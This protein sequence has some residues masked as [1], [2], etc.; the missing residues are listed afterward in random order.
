[1]LQSQ[2]VHRHDACSGSSPSPQWHFDGHRWL[3]SFLVLL[4][5]WE[6]RADWRK[7]VREFVQEECQPPRLRRELRKLLR[8]LER[9]SKQRDVWTA[10]LQEITQTITDQIETMT[11]A[12]LARTDCGSATI[13]SPCPETHSDC[14]VIAE[15]QPP[16]RTAEPEA[17]LSIAHS[18]PLPATMSRSVPIESSAMSLD[19]T[20]TVAPATTQGVEQFYGL[21]EQAP[22]ACLLVD[23]QGKVNYINAAGQLLFHEHSVTLGFGPDELVGN[24]YARLQQALPGLKKVTAH[25]SQVITL[26]DAKLEVSQRVVLNDLGRPVGTA[27]YLNNVTTLSQLQTDMTDASGKLDA[28]SRTN[29]VIEFQLDGTILT[30]NENFLSA[31]GYSLSEI[32]G[33]HHGIFADDAYRTSPEYREFWARLNRGENISGEMRRVAKGGREIWIRAIYS[34]MRDASGKL[35]KVVKF[36]TDIT[37]EVRSRASMADAAGKMEA[38]N[39]TNAVIEFKLD[40]TIVTANDNFL[41]AVGYS[42][43]EI[44]G[45]HH[46]MFVDSAYRMSPDY[47]EFWAKLNRGESVSGEMKRIA[48]GGREIWIRAIYAP[49]KDAQ[50][51]LSKVVKFA[52]EVTAE[53]KSREEAARI[54]NMMD[55]LPI[56]VVFAGKDTKISYVNPSAMR[57]LKKIEHLLPVPAE[58]LKGQSFDILHKA[59]EMQRRVVGDPRNLPHKARIKLGTETLDLLVSPITDS[60]GEYIGPMVTWSII[61]DQVKMADDFERDVK[62]VVQIVTSAATEM[63]ASSKNLAAASEETARQSQVVAAASEEATRNVETVSSSA[64]Q[65]S[66]SITEIARHVQ[67]ASKMTSMAVTEADKTNITI[68]QLGDSSNE[69]GQVVKVITSIAQQTNL[70]ALNATIEAA[71]AGEAGKG[72]AVVANEVKELARQTAKATEEIS[73][74]ISAIQGST[75]VAITAIGTISESIRKINEISTTIASAVEEQTAAT[76]EISRNVSEAARGTAEVSSNIAGVSQAADEGG[77][78]ASDILVASEGLAQES[79]RLDQVTSDFLKRMRSL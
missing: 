45:Q 29:A 78:G 20:T 48:K 3:S 51:N 13:S 41:S 47:R 16:P 73:Q 32:Q 19:S 75:G 39:R 21:I 31:L 64:E 17:N 28:V 7:F 66:K 4:R 18:L 52:T 63:Q 69:I 43:S 67:D 27:Y 71:R 2:A 8:L 55:N 34:P 42:L 9:E 76:N 72:F 40:G 33:K 11:A 54:Q 46:G 44:Q 77:R 15:A 58:Q 61:T 79:V 1:V 22:L 60:K 30:A 5:A 49:I 50:G 37:A 53:M 35:Y 70:L 68:K 59:P 38:V 6:E 25:D 36:A 57:T 62:G 26:G 10:S 12:G 24:A 14:E 65:L 56:N 74:K 23:P